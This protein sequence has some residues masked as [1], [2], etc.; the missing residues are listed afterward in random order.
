MQGKHV[1]KWR[2]KRSRSGPLATSQNNKNLPNVNRKVPKVDQKA[3]QRQPKMNL[4][5]QKT[6]MVAF[7]PHQKNDDNLES[8]FS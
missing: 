6:I 2:Q 7:V 8:V 3:P 5:L 4:R 1:S